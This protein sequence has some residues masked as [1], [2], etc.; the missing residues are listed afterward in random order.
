MTMKA[1]P[2]VMQFESNWFSTSTISPRACFSSMWR[3][4][5]SAARNLLEL[6]ADERGAGR[7]RRRRALRTEAARLAPL[8]IH[9]GAGCY[10]VDGH[11]QEA[12]GPYHADDAVNIIEEPCHARSSAGSHGRSQGTQNIPM[13]ISLVL[14]VCERWSSSF[15]CEH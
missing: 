8:L 6:R 1:V 13:T 2:G 15:G 11:V 3:C 14:S 5:V 12:L 9:L 7:G 10:T 4:C